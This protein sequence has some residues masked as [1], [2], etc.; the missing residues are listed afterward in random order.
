MSLALDAFDGVNDVG[1]AFHADGGRGAL[2][3]ASA[4]NRTLGRD[5]LVGHGLSF[6][7][8]ILDS[9]GLV[10]PRPAVDPTSARAVPTRKPLNYI[11]IAWTGRIDGA[12]ENVEK[13][14]STAHRMSVVRI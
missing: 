7:S 13:P 14:T 9:V 10:A 1:F 5:D 11:A 8:G 3:L 12:S 2:E 6:G 4:A